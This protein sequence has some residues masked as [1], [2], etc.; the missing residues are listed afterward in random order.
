MR[1]A[2]LHSAVLQPID[3]GSRIG[4]EVLHAVSIHGRGPVGGPPFKSTKEG[5]K[6]SSNG[7]NSYT[8]IVTYP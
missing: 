6:V 2:H 3:D 5:R 7:P 8:I 1:A 4:T